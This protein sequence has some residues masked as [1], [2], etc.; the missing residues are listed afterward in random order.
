L[1]QILTGVP[2][3]SI[4]GPL[5][6][7]IYINDLPECSDFLSKLFADDTALI[8]CDNDLERLVRKANVE[9][10][11][12]CMYFRS[13]KLSLHPDKTKYIIIS[14]SRQ[15]HDTVTKICINNNNFNQNDPSLIF[16]IKR[17]LPTDDIPA[18]KYLGVYFDPNLN[19]KY[20]LQQLSF[21]LSRALFQIRRV[22]NILTKEAMKT[23]YFS[24]FHC[25]LVYAIEIWS[26][27]SKSLINDLYLKQKVA[28]RIVSNSNYNSHTAPIFKKLEILPIHMLIQLHLSKIMYFSRTTVFQNASITPG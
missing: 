11:K 12:V 26:L 16:E 24:L 2:Q 22:K 8:L 17:V 3:G 15:V 13:N 4:L 9:F 27:A 7:L 20:H 14:N 25:H 18:I 23:L 28:V 1:L 6:F 10:Q 21:K 19:F 5:L